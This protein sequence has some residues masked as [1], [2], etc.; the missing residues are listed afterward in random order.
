MQKARVFPI[1]VVR[2]LHVH[3]NCLS[4]TKH[5][6]VFMMMLQ[7]QTCCSTQSLAHK[8]VGINEQIVSIAGG[9]SMILYGLRPGSKLRLVSLLAGAGLVY[10][11]VTGHCE[12]YQRL[13]VDSAQDEK[14]PGV[15]HGAGQLVKASVQINRDPRDLYDLWRNL[16]NLPQVMKHLHSVTPLEGNRSHWIAEGPLGHQLEWDAEVINDHPGDLIAW[17]SLPGA[18][19]DNA[20]SVHFRPSANGMGTDLSVTIRYAPPGGRAIAKLAS[21]FG[22]GLQQELREDLRRFK[23]QM[24]TGE[25]TTAAIS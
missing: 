13:G 1:V 14:K 2:Q 21:V 10:R 12:V 11:G 22:Q 7:N 25:V 6:G 16:P 3:A 4:N 5:E 9:A 24:E 19:V 15:K 8:N 20:G 18:E 17:Q 23:Q